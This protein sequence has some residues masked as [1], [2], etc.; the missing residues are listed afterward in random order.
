MPTATVSESDPAPAPAPVI[1]PRGGRR[2]LAVAAVNAPGGAETTLLRLLGRLGERGWQVTLVTPGDGPLRAAGESAG[3]R[4]L[5]LPVGGL[6]AG[7][8]TRAMLSWPRARRLAGEVDV[9][10]LN[11]TVCGRLL[12]A[13]A[14][15]RARRV[16]HV[17]DLVTRVPRFWRLADLVLAAS[18]A[19]A[20][21][22]GSL[23][24]HVVY[25]PVDADPPTVAPPWP[26][27]EGPV[28]GFIGRI[29][30]RKGAMDL[31]RAAPAIRAG[32]PGARV[33]VVG[34]DP[35]R[36]DP[37]YTAAVTGSPEIEHHGWVANAPGLMRHL[38]VL[39]LPSYDEPFGTVLAEAMAVGT[40][41]VATRVGGLAEVVDDG[42]T[43][44]LVAPGDPAALAAAVLEVL[45]G[46][47]AMGAAA[48]ERARRFDGERYAAHVERLLTV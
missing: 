9:V 24:S 33:M 26:C 22:L 21:R 37:A 29:E 44:R 14:G 11:G 7:T 13:L 4:C 25:G 17:H 28:V 2:I 18:G 45:R 39:V 32:A 5:A 3:H 48:R 36:S 10:Y 19:V 43:G 27:D 8:G 1:E 20:A 47:D 30:P 42:V 12:P 40:P 46:R 38:D 16:L 15:S 35:Y 31:V 23:T 34:E 41:V 6:G